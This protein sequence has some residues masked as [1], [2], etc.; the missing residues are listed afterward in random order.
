MLLL[1]ELRKREGDDTKICLPDRHIILSRRSERRMGF[2]SV[3][4]ASAAT[5][6]ILQLQKLR[7]LRGLL[8]ERKRKRKLLPLQPDYKPIELPKISTFSHSI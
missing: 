7:F 8:S 2:S 1:L 3:A 5:F 6:L 4:A